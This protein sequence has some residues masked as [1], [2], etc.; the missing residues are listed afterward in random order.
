MR[1]KIGPPCSLTPDDKKRLD[2]ALS[3]LSLLPLQSRSG[4]IVV[5][6]HD[7]QASEV[8]SI[9]KGLGFDVDE[10]QSFDSRPVWGSLSRPPSR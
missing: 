1:I 8:M 2:Q 10:M 4:R 7:A 5:D 3:D 6:V 9:L